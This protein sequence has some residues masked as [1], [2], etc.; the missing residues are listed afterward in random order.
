MKRLL[1]LC[2]CLCIVAT[3]ALGGCARVEND[4]VRIKQG[5][6]DDEKKANSGGAKLWR[7]ACD[8][9]IGL[10]R[11]SDAMKDVPQDQ[12]DKVLEGAADE[13]FEE[14]KSVASDDPETADKSAVCILGLDRFDP[15][16]FEACEPS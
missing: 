4:T 1:C 16:A 9:A 3:L 13:C 6:T 10:M 8:H 7:K 12:L 14:F 5:T 15:K 2:L 11:T